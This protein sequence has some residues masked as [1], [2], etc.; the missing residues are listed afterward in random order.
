MYINL[1]VAPLHLLSPSCSRPFLAGLKLLCNLGL[2]MR[3]I[4]LVPVALAVSAAS[5]LPRS[6]VERGL[7]NNA[8]QVSSSDPQTS[9]SKYSDFSLS[10]RRLCLSV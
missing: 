9:L 7:G 8:R 4:A 5:A 6:A 1:L 2:P 10:S 3:L